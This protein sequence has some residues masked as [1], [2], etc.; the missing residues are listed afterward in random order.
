MVTEIAVSAGGTSAGPAAQSP[1]LSVDLPTEFSRESLACRAAQQNLEQRWP[2]AQCRTQVKSQTAALS[3]FSD[4]RN[5]AALTAAPAARKV[6]AR[7]TQAIW[8]DHYSDSGFFGDKWH[9]CPLREGGCRGYCT[10][11]GA[12]RREAEIGPGAD[13]SQMY[14]IMGTVTE[15]AFKKMGINE[16]SSRC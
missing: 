6:T 9:P 16:P 11:S 13:A 4:P 3:S 2:S 8:S 12:V 15:F 7:R 10:V 1:E 14:G 5:S